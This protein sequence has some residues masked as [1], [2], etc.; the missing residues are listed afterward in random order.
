MEQGLASGSSDFPLPHD[1]YPYWL[2]HKGEGHSVIFNVPQDSDCH[3]KG[4]ALCVVY[5]STPENMEIEYLSVLIANHTKCTIQIYKRETPI[6]F[7]DEEWLDILSNLEPGDLVEILV[8]FELGL[9]IKKTAVY[10]LYGDST[11]V[12]MEPTAKPKK[13]LLKTFVKKVTKLAIF[14]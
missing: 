7:N 3:L 12:K 10:L 13:S 2:T 5:S 11:S 9:T 4:M 14:D 6:S 8:V 1:N